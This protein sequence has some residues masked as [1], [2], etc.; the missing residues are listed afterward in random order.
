MDDL[1]CERDSLKFNGLQILINL[2]TI[3]TCSQVIYGMAILT[4]GFMTRLLYQGNQYC[5]VN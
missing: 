2:Q 1:S 4:S 5:V 3:D